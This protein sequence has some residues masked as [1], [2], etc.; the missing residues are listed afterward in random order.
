MFTKSPRPLAILLVLVVIT[1]ALIALAFQPSATLGLAWTLGFAVLALNAL[2]G[3]LWSARLF[4]GL[5]LL[6][7]GLTPLQLLFHPQ[8][9]LGAT[10]GAGWSVLLLVTGVYIL[11]SATVRAFYAATRSQRDPEHAP[12]ASDA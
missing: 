3:A 6:V 4:A 11:R 12:S 2:R 8:T 5:C 1:R 9:P 10:A 7:G